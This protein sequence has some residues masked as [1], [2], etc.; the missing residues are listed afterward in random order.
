MCLA[1]SSARVD[2]AR[3]EHALSALTLAAILSAMFVA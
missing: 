1:S 3:D 2:L